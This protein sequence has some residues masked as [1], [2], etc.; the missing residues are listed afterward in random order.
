ME[1]FGS[2]RRVRLINGFVREGKTPER[3]IIMLEQV[4]QTNP[5][6]T[7]IS[8][9]LDRINELLS[10]TDEGSNDVQFGTELYT[11]TIGLLETVHGPHDSR[12]RE[13]VK[14]REQSGNMKINL[15]GQMMFLI[16]AC[17][18]ALADLKV[19]IEN[20]LIGSVRQEIA[21]EVLSDFILLAKKALDENR[22]DSKNVAAVLIA[23]SF[24]DALRRMGA[25]LADIKEKIEL[26]DVVIGLKNAGVLK[27]PKLG[28]VQ[29][30]LSFR[31]RALHAQWGEIDKETVK[32][33]IGMVESLL[34]QYLS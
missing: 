1:S 20:D 32:N 21:G 3:K 16:P 6:S 2:L 18:G 24:E 19:C 9:V 30:Y 31:N 12:K 34:I 29:S 22:E 13:L 25:N 27:S 11:T 15:R 7:V 10:R 26:Q 33:A 23:A 8:R 17:K 5:K 28:I 14:I 4:N